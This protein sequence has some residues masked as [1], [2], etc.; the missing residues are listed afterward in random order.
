MWKSYKTSTHPPIHHSSY[1]NL[2]STAEDNSGSEDEEE[3]ECE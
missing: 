2:Q 3:E 1:A